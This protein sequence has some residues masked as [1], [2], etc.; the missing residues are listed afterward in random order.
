MRKM[1]ADILQN[2]LIVKMVMNLQR[3]IL[4]KEKIGQIAGSVDG[5]VCLERGREKNVSLTINIMSY[6]YGHLAA[7][8]IESV[9]NQT[10]RPDVIRFYDDGAGDCGHLPFIYPEVAYTLRPHNLGIIDNFNDALEHTTT[11]RVMFLGADNWLAPEAVARCMEQAAEIV[12]YDAYKVMDT[13]YQYWHLA[14]FPHGSA[15]YDVAL[16]KQVGGYARSDHPDHTEE[17][18]ILFSKLLALGA[19]LHIIEEPLLYY[20]WRHR[21]N[22]NQ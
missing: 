19:E 4:I 7:H 6:R 22:F 20:R 8:C 16:A 21:R 3:I 11:D 9:L 15:V 14:G 1:P 2:N 18:N 12:S 5:A 13:S 17:D 10:V